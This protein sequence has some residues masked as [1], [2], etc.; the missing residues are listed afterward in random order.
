MKSLKKTRR[1]QVILIT[2]LA[3]IIAT[4]LIGF[5][6]RDGI[7]LFRSPTQVLAEPPESDEYFQIGGL[8][9]EGSMTPVDGVAFNFVITDGGAEVPVAYI[10][11]EPR[12]DLFT[13][14]T[15]TIAK[16]YYVD[17][18]FKADKLLAK[19]DETY[20]PKE[21]IDAL[22]EQGVYQEPDS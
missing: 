5:A 10:G 22:K 6:M 7:N 9:K 1:I 18:T 4:G 14:G 11:G 8:V 15:G 19:H 16:G 12:P 13:E 20:M 3:L 21:V 2:V 17:G